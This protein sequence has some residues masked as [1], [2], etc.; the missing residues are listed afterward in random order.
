MK[1]HRTLDRSSG[2]PFL[3]Q[4]LALLQSVLPLAAR[5][6]FLK[7]KPHPFIPLHKTHWLLP[8]H[9]PISQCGVFLICPQLTLPGA[10]PPSYNFFSSQPTF[11]STPAL[12]PIWSLH[13]Y[14]LCAEKS[15][16]SPSLVHPNTEGRRCEDTKT[17]VE[18]HV[19]TEA[20][21][22]VRHPQT[23][24]CQGMLATPEARHGTDSSLWPWREE[25][26]ATTLISDI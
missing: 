7:P 5:V 8:L 20:E 4:I 18:S 26:S 3:G 13:L 12:S 14:F 21:I 23:K 19:V 16:S 9:C 17:Q 2:L 25:G 15:V 11:L 6:I 10:N 22:G 24:E 1:L